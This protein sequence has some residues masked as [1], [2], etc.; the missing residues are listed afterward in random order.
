MYLSVG[1]CVFYKNAQKTKKIKFFIEI[2]Y[3]IFLPENVLYSI[4]NT[5][6]P[7]KR[8]HYCPLE[9]MVEGIF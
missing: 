9:V 1:F 7:F 2:D 3:R 5:V 8:K 4:Y 6:R